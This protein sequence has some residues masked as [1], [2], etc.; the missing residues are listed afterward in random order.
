MLRYSLLIRDVIFVIFIEEVLCFDLT[1]MLQ[2]IHHYAVRNEIVHTNLLAL[3]KESGW[4]VSYLG[5]EVI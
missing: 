4:Q 3:V 1:D 2:N 5:K